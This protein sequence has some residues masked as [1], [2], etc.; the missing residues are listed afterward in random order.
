[1]AL[2]TAISLKWDATEANERR[3]LP[4]VR[5][6]NRV[7]VN[8]RL[9]MASATIDLPFTLALAVYVISSP[10]GLVPIWLRYGHLPGSNTGHGNPARAGRKPAPCQGV[11]HQ[12][13]VHTERNINM[14]IVLEYDVGIEEE[15][16]VTNA[17]PLE[18][19]IDGTIKLL[20][21]RARE[22]EAD[23]YIAFW[24]K[25]KATLKTLWWKM[26]SYISIERSPRRQSMTAA[27]QTR[28]LRECVLTAAVAG[29]LSKDQIIYIVRVRCRNNGF[30]ICDREV[31]FFLERLVNRKILDR[32]GVDYIVACD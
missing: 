28:F 16:E 8:H 19:W 27:S 1:M 4:N 30:E 13:N 10:S 18:G 23:E 12:T 6:G 9:D 14:H 17:G 25:H 26:R 22:D 11:E 20:K 7:S 5:V 29:N 31:E 2:S 15:K 3:D 32:D 24:T 21:E